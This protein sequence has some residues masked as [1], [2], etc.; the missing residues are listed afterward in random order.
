VVFSIIKFSPAQKQRAEVLEILRSVHD[1]TRPC[2][3]CL[4]CWLSEEDC[5]HNQVCFAEQWESEEALHEHLRSELYRRVLAAMELSKHP[6]EVSFHYV[7]STKGFELVEAIRG[8]LAS[9]Q[10]C[11]R[12]PVGR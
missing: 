4:G 8:R 11:V 7:T 2:P 5:F 1:L 10:D 9:S 3:G 12:K 6:P